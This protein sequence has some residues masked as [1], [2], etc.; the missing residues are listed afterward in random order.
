[1]AKLKNPKAKGDKYERELAKYFN[2]VI[3]DG[4]PRVSRAP[5]SG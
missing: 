5:L 4:E 2:D 1:M 3:F